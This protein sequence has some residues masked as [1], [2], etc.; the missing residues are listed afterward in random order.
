MTRWGEALISAGKRLEGAG[1]SSARLDARLL[2][3]EVLKVDP[4]VLFAYPENDLTAEE[5]ERFASLLERR[6][7]REP[8]SHILG[9][10]EF[11]SLPFTVTNAVLDPRPDTE[12]LIEAVLEQAPDREKPLRILDLGTGSGCILLTLLSEY[13]N[14]SGVGVDISEAA[15]S[16]A[17]KNARD[18]ELDRRADFIQGSW[19][20]NIEGP[21]DVI[22]SNPPYIPE[23]EIDGL[24]P[25]VARF[26]PRLA[27]SGGMDGLDCYRLLAPNIASLLVPGGVAALEIGIGQNKNVE[28]LLIRAG[29]RSL[30]AKCDLSAI[31][32][33]VIAIR[34]E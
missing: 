2:L 17:K 16:V 20:K 26:E 1:V 12:T 13:P 10:R 6:A 19:G 22:V 11:W 28:D 31:I 29:L 27:L 5:D 7:A 30:P 21:F 18:L 8:V 23:G 3:A 33:V 25:E 34:D 9:R 24:E 15:L 4:H 14:A 32:R